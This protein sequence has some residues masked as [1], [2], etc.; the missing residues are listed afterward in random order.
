MVFKVPSNPNHSVILKELQLKAQILQKLTLN[1]FQWNLCYECK[2]ILVL[3]ST[4]LG[5]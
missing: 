2:V 1:E 3:V 5:C 4:V